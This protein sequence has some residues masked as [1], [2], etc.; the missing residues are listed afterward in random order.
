[1]PVPLR[2][3]AV[4]GGVDRTLQGVD[5]ARISLLELPSKTVTFPCGAR[6]ELHFLRLF[7]NLMFVCAKPLPPLPHI[8]DP[9]LLLCQLA[10]SALASP[11]PGLLSPGQ[12]WG[13]WLG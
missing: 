2:D 4:Q 5:H 13:G 3:T 11:F 12:R 8:T 10:V 6:V 9:Q 7:S 1:M